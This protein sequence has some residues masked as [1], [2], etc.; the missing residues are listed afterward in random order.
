MDSAYAASVFFVRRWATLKTEKEETNADQRQ[1]PF[2][3][4]F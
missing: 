2:L 4:K 1:Q 3:L